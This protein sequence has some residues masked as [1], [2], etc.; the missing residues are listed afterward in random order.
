MGSS[1]TYRAQDRELLEG[2]GGEWPKSE[3]AA[4]GLLKRL[5]SAASSVWEE[6]A[7]GPGREDGLVD[8]LAV[9]LHVG[10]A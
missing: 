8:R 3:A 7:V 4:I 2:G 5:G 10:D 6:P 1:H 9:W